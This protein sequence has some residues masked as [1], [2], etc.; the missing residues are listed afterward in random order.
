MPG[1]LVELIDPGIVVREAGK[2]CYLFDSATLQTIGA[3]LLERITREDAAHVPTIQQSINFPYREESSKACFLCEDITKEQELISPKQCPGCKQ[4]LPS[5]PQRVLE[6]MGA[7]ILF[8]PK[9]LPTSEPR[10]LCLKPSP[11]CVFY[12][13]KSKGTKGNLKINYATSKC[14]NSMEF[15]YGVAQVSGS[16]NPCSNVPSPCPF[17]PNSASAV[18]MYNMKEHIR[19][20]HLYVNLSEHAQVWRI[21]ES[22]KA[23]M[24]QIWSTRKNVKKS[25]KSK[26]AKPTL[27]I[28]EAHSSRLALLQ[29]SNEDD[30]DA[31]D[32][33]EES[34]EEAEDARLKAP[35]V[36]DDR[37]EM[38]L[39]INK[40]TKAP[41]KMRA[42]LFI[43]PLLPRLQAE[44]LQQSVPLSSDQKDITHRFRSRLIMFKGPRNNT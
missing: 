13:T 1:R 7:H 36:S 5:T 30:P 17:C 31:F 20:K 14:S 44:Q 38:H 28:S 4:D 25:R 10:G 27:E 18:W 22:E 32:L 11:A 12:L 42:S 16:S 19:T 35:S 39:P 6:H 8:D 33:A 2:P 21:L 43:I 23:A 24:K 40:M 41:H 15:N 37:E 26:K 3:V 34:N 29:P 9:V